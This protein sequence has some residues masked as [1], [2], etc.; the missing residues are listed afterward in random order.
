MGKNIDLLE[1]MQAVDIWGQKQ[2]VYFV[3]RSK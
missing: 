1:I 3:K 2:M